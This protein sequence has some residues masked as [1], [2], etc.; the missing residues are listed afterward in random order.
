MILKGFYQKS[1]NPTNPKIPIYDPVYMTLYM[2]LVVIEENNILIGTQETCL[3]IQL[4]SFSIQL[5]RGNT[6]RGD[7][8]KVGS[9]CKIPVPTRFFTKTMK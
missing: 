2:I 8:H 3:L 5:Q 7:S 1:E 4:Q 9:E 6:N